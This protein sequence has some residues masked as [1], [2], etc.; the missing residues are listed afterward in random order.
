MANVCDNQ[1]RIYT[2]NEENQKY[3]IDFLKRKLNANI[4]GNNTD[5]EAYFGSKWMF[6]ADIMD[7]L[8]KGMPNK[9]DIDMT[10]LSVEWGCYYCEFHSC[11]KD[12]WSID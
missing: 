6:P 11:D 7:E 12:G 8:Y 5:I 10:C 3:V 2:E 9:D 1:L 4:E